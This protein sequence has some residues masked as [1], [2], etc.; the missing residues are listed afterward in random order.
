M[1]QR[2]LKEGLLMNLQEILY[3][4]QARE[5][6]PED[7]QKEIQ[8]NVMKDI[9]IK[10][11]EQLEAL[12]GTDNKILISASIEYLKVLIAEVTKIPIDRLDADA[13]FEEL[14][15][16][17]IMISYL[18]QKIEQWVGIL[19]ATLFF[20]YNSIKTLGN[21]FLEVYPDAV[22]SLVNKT[23]AS[24]P[25][26]TDT[27]QHLSFTKES[28]A[29][30]SPCSNKI[31][32]FSMVSSISNAYENTDIAIIGVAGRYPKSETL[33]QFWKN[34][35]EGKDCIEEIPPNRWSLDGFFEPDRAKALAEGLSYSKWGGFLDNIDHFDPLF[36]NI[37]PRDA[38]FMDPQERLFL[39]V[40]WECLEDSGYTRKSLEKYE[41]SN[42]IGVFVGAT[43]NNYQL[44]MTEAAQRA[45][46]DMYVASSQ[47]FSIANRVSYVMDFT[48]PSL[49]VDTACSSS[50]YAV[51]LACE[52]I[53]SGQ[54]RMAIAGGVN[55]SLHP[56]KYIT[57]CQGQFNA[58]D[59]R[60]RAFCEGGTGYVPSEAVGA[61]FLKP[62][63]D[64]INEHD[65]IYGVI[66]G[67]AT[68]H[69]GKTNGFTV[70]S[71]VSQSL[72]IE[73][74]MLQGRIHPR[75]ISCIEAHGT[76]TALGDPIEI[77]GLTD[78]FR[79]YTQET[80]FCSISSVKSN[81]GHAEAAAGI[82]QLTKVLLQFKHQTLV[83]NVMHGKGLNP[84]IDF[85]KTPF[86]V[87]ENTE[88]WKRPIIDGQEV[89]R[90]AG[91]SS[92]GAGGANAHV[93]IEEYICHDK[94]QPQVTTTAQ[95]PLL[96]V[97]SAKN[98]QCLKKQV[99][100]L[101]ASIEEQQFSDLNLADIAYTLQI[102]REAMEERLA[103]VVGSIKELKEK[104]K[105]IVEGRE[106]DLSDLYRGQVKQN[107][108]AIAILA[109]DEGMVATIDTWIS[110]G[111]FVKLLDLW[112]K[113]LNCDWD[114]LYGSIKPRR[115]SL[116]AYPFVK[117]RYWVPEVEA[118]SVGSK[119]VT[120]GI[121]A[122]IHPLLH[123]NTSDLS[124]QRFSST[125]T[126]QEFF[127]KNHV[128]K[129]QRILPGVAYLEMARAA[130]EQASASLQESQIK[131]RLKN[132]VWT[133]PIAVGERPVQVQ[134]GLFP[135]D[136]GA[137]AYEIYSQSEA[138]DAEFVVHSQGSAV[139]SSS[140]DVQVLDIK[141]L[142]AQCNKSTLSSSECYK[143]FRS[144]GIEYGL[145]HQG[146]EKVFVGSDQ[147]LARLILP[148]YLSETQDQFVLHPSIMDSA[149]QAT[150]GLMMD[151]GNFKPALPFALQDIEILGSCTSAM[152][153]LIRYSDG[154]KLGD[155][156]QKIDIELCDDQ[157]AICVRIKG[158]STRV[159]ESEIGSLGLAP[160]I[161]TLML[162]PSWKEQ[163]VPQ[164]DPA[165]E[166][167]EHVVMLCEVNGISQKGIETYQAGV[168]VITLQ[169][170]WKDID[171]G[172]IL[173]A[174]QAFEEIQCIIK[175]KPKGNV[176][177]Q[178]VVSTQK[179][180]Q[181]FSALSGLLKTA[182]LE[183]PKL[184]GQLIEVEPGT[185]LESIIEKLKENS[186]CPQDNQIRYR[187]GKRWVAD[188]SE[189]EGAQERIP[190][191]EQ[192]IYLITGGVGGL[193]L[194]FAKEIVQQVKNTTLI[195]TG[196]SSLN[197]KKQAKLKELEAMG[198]RIEYKQVDITDK[199]AVTR[200]IQSIQENNG[201]LHGIIHC[202][203]VIRDSFIIKKNKEELQEVLGPKVTGLVN[204][205]QACKDM[206]LDF[207][208]LFSS[209]TGSLG[210]PGQADYSM[211]NAFMDV[212]AGY[213]N[214]L[215]EL[216]ERHGRTLSM[217]WPLWK[218]GGMNVNTEIE[219]L[220]MQNTGMI[221]M[222]T[223]TGIQALYQGLASGGNQVMV[224]EGKLSRMK[225][226]L[227]SIM[228][229]VIPHKKK[230][231]ESDLTTRIDANSLRDKVQAILIEA[232]YKILK[233]NTEDIDVNTELSEYGFDSI[234]F[235][236][237]SNKLNQEHKLELT[238][239]IFFEYPTI[240]NL[241]EYLIEEHYTS[242][243]SQIMV[244]NKA[245][246]SE[247]AIENEAEESPIL[248]RQRSRFAKKIVPSASKFDTPTQGSI[249]IVGM[250]GR[251]PEAKDINEFWG[252][253]VDGKD[254]ITEIPKDRWDWREYYG[255]CTKEA[256]KTN[257]KWGG[258]INGV[259]E[260]DPLFF[261]ISPKEAE[262]MDPKQRLLLT[263]VW[264][265]IEDAGISPKGMSE[266][267]TG[268]FIAA[269]PSQDTDAA[270]MQNNSLSLTFTAPAVL[271]TRISYALN[272]H[273][274]SEYYDT[275][276]SSTLVALH[277][278]V[279]AIHSGECEQAIV[280]AVNLLISPIG[281]I[282]LDSMGYLSPEGKAKPFQ[283]G[284]N[285]YVRSEGVGV[286]VI[287]PLQKAI[288][289]QDRIYAVVRGTGVSHG[290]KGMSLTAPN[291]NGMKAAMI[292]A[293]QVANIDPRTVSYIEAHGI[294]SPLGDGIEINAL[295]AA[296][297]K[298][299]ASQPQR[300][301]VK[302]PCYISSLKS[303]IGHAEAASGMAA[304]IKAI[305]AMNHR[306]IPRIPQFETLSEYISLEGSPFKI[307]T[308]NYEWEA[309]K[310]VNGNSLPR[311]ASINSYGFSGIN[312]HLVLEEYTPLQEKMIPIEVKTSLQVLTLSAKNNNRLKDYAQN[313]LVFLKKTQG[314]HENKNNRS[315]IVENCIKQEII[316]YLSTLIN[317]STVDIDSTQNFV[318]QNIDYVHRCTM[319][320]YLQDKWKIDIDS[321]FIMESQ[322]IDELVTFLSKHYLKDV[323]N[324][325]G[326]AK[327]ITDKFDAYL[328]IDLADIAYTFQ[329]GRE[330]ME[331]RVAFVVNNI[332]ELIQK[333]EAF[334]DGKENIEDCFIGDVK[335][336]KDTVNLFG[337]DDDFKELIHK[338]IAKGKVKKIAELWSK[339]LPVEW[340]LLYPDK[341]PQRISVPTYPFARERYGTLLQQEKS[342]EMKEESKAHKFKNEDSVES[343]LRDTLGY[344]TKLIQDILG[345]ASNYT[346]D[347]Q[348]QLTEYGMDSISGI[349]LLEKLRRELGIQLDGRRFFSEFT[350]QSVI[351]QLGS[352]TNQD[353][354]FLLPWEMDKKLPMS[355]TLNLEN[356]SFKHDSSPD[357]IFLTGATGLLGA[358]LCNEI[359]QQT[360]AIVYCLVR[361][362]S[363]SL[364]L[365]RIQE[366]FNKYE[367]WQPDYQSRII[368]VLGDITKPQLGIE[369]IIY[370][371]L[372]HSIGTI[373]H[374]A[375]L[376]NHILNYYS[377]K[378]SNVNGTLS[379]IEFAGNHKIKS[380]HFT[381]TVGVC[382]QMD[383]DTILPPHQMEILLDHGRNLSS[384]YAQSKW[385]SEHH[386]MQAQEKGIPITI[387]RCGEITGSSQTGYGIAEDM[388]HNFLKIFSE[389]KVIPEWDEGVLDIIPIDY[390]SKVM[391]AVSQQKDCYGKIYNL[392]HVQP[393]PIRD[394]FAFLQ[395][396]NSRLSKVSFVEW[397]DCCLHYIN[398]LPESAA[399]TIM[400]GFFTKLDTGPRMFEYYFTDLR[401]ST[402]NLQ[403]A[404]QNTE[405]YFPQMD[406]P[407]W[408]KCIKHISLFD[409][410]NG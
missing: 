16:D 178:V 170:K 59:G 78:V 96:I 302:N 343:N 261:G 378:N 374:C 263:Y 356:T 320:H 266:D 110:K 375:A 159:L 63:Q 113:G 17:S 90:R 76:G 352:A 69:G 382:S 308:E 46:R 267:S 148:S 236:A 30:I 294:A 312:A 354:V 233:V 184:I 221:T 120:S 93:I 57:L 363:T 32:P 130:V 14:G 40:A 226:T 362:E 406:D 224:M 269:C 43:F 73:K 403:K 387:F 215:V 25:T 153:A 169:S 160:T 123:K 6:S 280:G 317:I 136:N 386:L 359:L 307:A 264:R 140:V 253:I 106:G 298:I 149:L 147:V 117:E 301:Q 284:A 250:S 112:V 337:K 227:L 238:P 2:F 154:S 146:I 348:V 192:G 251:F 401:L 364:G 346:I 185:D 19:D 360:S 88:Y 114:K 407:W 222:K 188:W 34:L 176:L 228:N 172:F 268:V 128:V 12:T 3:A 125:F 102:G 166:Y 206:D 391:L 36:F 18:N 143:A 38:M 208:V 9:K 258:F 31:S 388:V 231:G 279:Q 336:G 151:A 202:A 99:Q 370:N 234:T 64:A 351:S 358:F 295:K 350:L 278:A 118:K 49:T 135:E 56:S 410:N 27:H 252:N 249:A 179:E 311:R 111:E 103:V 286:I 15:L 210:N 235:T 168:R 89:P 44:F 100:R 404:L 139:L 182:Q 304:L 158:F 75:S 150:I 86:V 119:A 329:V 189:I 201:S 219:K 171:E 297:Q 396:K 293:Y 194:I 199:K 392:N 229:P 398:D 35:Y 212:Y 243:T 124:E 332:N 61:I 237:F 232:V 389:V 82:T 187:F 248:N 390:V 162:Q 214:D 299:T 67:S 306:L 246:N 355:L 244:S 339:G 223:G 328:E 144:M 13:S 193:G 105:K 41:G 216:K 177:I 327:K 322:S 395:K 366:N 256:N 377:L 207:F 290:G 155:K 325:Y 22:S 116:P 45:N 29:T 142:Q 379:I 321:E 340:G 33:E 122:A 191:K 163:V 367:L 21:Y 296:Y 241:V 225:Q 300:V 385:V 175:N 37:S 131:I 4:L 190:W 335:Q 186:Q 92:F 270:S 66:K 7:A 161:G 87:Q 218:E 152:W 58:A 48:G 255:D 217:N 240:Q 324:Y 74:A 26:L 165:L 180:Q 259:D 372:S 272:L 326:I 303:S 60:C 81:V 245:E 28:S 196:R 97:L 195:L 353:N 183:N 24:M 157:G 402:K 400:A 323:A 205:D 254:C 79:K 52:S 39:E 273:G 141:A 98:E 393:F 167:I 313:L 368:P 262:F 315:Q 257:I 247:K 77:A 381:S 271:P 55:L 341:K 276:C 349:Q 310:D 83:K 200:L 133:R 242:F 198:S 121:T 50:L 71:P 408:E 314:H 91:I 365:Q 65:L 47:T 132:V 108:K 274:P 8:S 309:L 72:A 318:E 54:S 85:V 134:I 220:M 357:K 345:L 213:R 115:I 5:I 397:A 204:L 361:A 70:P 138:S 62:L 68:S 409:K 129:G 380:I 288:N 164:E 371:E 211:A 305:L 107:K 399:K 10:T 289:D 282:G 333:L 230:S 95:S 373:Y 53:R 156:I 383:G 265:A 197:D 405:V 109:A 42:Q 281:F 330:A 291:V 344:I 316:N 126:G 319:H 174:T 23:T 203:G 342:L 394:F 20:K 338:W 275:A 80:E 287:K 384:G 260:F 181:L 145:G 369:K 331:N 277:R 11:T 292:Q 1:I 173:Y 285:G 51:H 239:T 283:I 101:L 347:P 94:E 84:N 104:L 127:L 137:I 334:I 209:I 376:P